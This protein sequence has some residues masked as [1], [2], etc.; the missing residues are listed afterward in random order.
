MLLS[1]LSVFVF[2][3]AYTQDFEYK[4]YKILKGDTLWDISIKEIKDPFLWPKVWK[5]N[6]DIEN[7]DRIFPNQTIKIPLRLIKKEGE[8]EAGAEKAAAVPGAV[9]EEEAAKAAE[10]KKIVPVHTTYIADEALVAASGYISSYIET[11]D[12]KSK[13]K[14]TGT[15][16]GRKLLGESDFMYIKTNEPANTGDKFY[17]M[18]PTE[19]IRHPKTKEKVGYHIAVL[20]IAE[21]IG[22]ENGDTKAKILKSYGDIVLGDLLDTYYEIIPVIDDKAP[23]TPDVSG[24]V[25]A[26]SYMKLI[27]GNFDILFIDRGKKDGLEVG[28]LL[29]IKSV[30]KY[31][32]ARTSGAIQ[33]ISMRDTTATAIVRKTESAINVGDEVLEMK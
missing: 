17:I 16:T 26:S 32:N 18:R 31:N 25:I 10:E 5:E 30:D 27:S 7:P 9:K 1:A 33:I 19:L 28:D 12:I 20:G 8:E 11:E 15:P 29:K 6:P 3:T 21:V 2:S 23:R 22:V 24:F 13:G 14:I 4:E